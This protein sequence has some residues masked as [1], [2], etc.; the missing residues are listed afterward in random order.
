MRYCCCCLLLLALTLRAD[1]PALRWGFY[2]HR[3]INRMA[4]WTLDADMMPFFRAQ[5]DYLS[6][7]AVDPDKRRYASRHEAVRHYIDLDRWGQPPFAD[8]PRS[9]TDALLQKAKL[10]YPL[11]GTDTIAWSVQMIAQASTDTA[12]LLMSSS[13]GDTAWLP[14]RPYRQVFAAGVLPHYYEERWTLPADSL[15]RWLPLP[16]ETRRVE[17]I[18]HLSPHGILPYHLERVQRQLTEAFRR[19]QRARILRLCADLGHYIADAHVP[20]HT[21]ENYDGQLSGQRGIHA[22]WESR[23]P[24]L[25]AESDYDLFVGKAV[26]IDHPRNFFWQI[27]LDSHALVDRV[28]QTERR[29]RASYPPAEQYCFEL[30]GEQTLR[31]PCADYAAAYQAAMGNMVEERLRAAIHAVGSAWFTAWVDAGQ[32]DLLRGPDPDPSPGADS[33]GSPPGRQQPAVR[34]HE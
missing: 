9:W 10:R 1:A 8:L 17:V 25:F 14:Y 4:V 19:R 12:R 16:A 20:L 7:H 26:Y 18:D 23:I 2:G 15:R 34:P 21:T 28:L 31:Q 13:A 32:P 5:L 22:F 6:D 24:E 27:V 3:L 29:L 11:A 30:R 33:L